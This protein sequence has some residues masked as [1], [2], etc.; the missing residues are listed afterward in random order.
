MSE[1]GVF[2]PVEGKLI[3]S[4]D[5]W[6]LRGVLGRWPDKA[7]TGVSCWLA[8][9]SRFRE[10]VSR[11]CVSFPVV[12][13]IDDRKKSA[14]ACDTRCVMAKSDHCECICLGKNHKG[15]SG[16]NSL[17][18]VGETALIE[19]SVVRIEYVHRKTT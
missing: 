11:A 17:E 2:R 10:I 8:P 5:R 13:V 16:I 3:V 19:T 4:C 18:L 12:R 6:W 14:R 15:L 9:R 7:P 1:V